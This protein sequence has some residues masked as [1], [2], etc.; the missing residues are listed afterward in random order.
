VTGSIATPGQV[1]RHYVH[2]GDGDQAGF[3]SLTN[4]SDMNW[5]LDAGGNVVSAG[6]S[7]VRMA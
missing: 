7:P 3:D 6:R 2:P 1:Q 4:R 5:S